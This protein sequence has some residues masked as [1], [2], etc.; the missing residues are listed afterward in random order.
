MLLLLLILLLLLLLLLLLFLLLPL[1]LMLLRL[2]LLLLL[3]LK[4][5]D[6][7]MA[8]CI[9]LRLPELDERG[10]LLTRRQTVNTTATSSTTAFQFYY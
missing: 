10:V 4:L 5:K 7:A 1:K 6:I 2:I 9:K 8:N 3:L